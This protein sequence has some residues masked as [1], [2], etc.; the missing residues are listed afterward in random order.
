MGF[1]MM[2][3]PARNWLLPLTAALALAL[4]LS[5]DAF[6][7]P[8]NEPG[9]PQN[10]GQAMPANAPARSPDEAAR[11]AARQYDAAKVLS[12]KTVQQGNRKVHVVKLLTRDGVVKTVRVPADG[13]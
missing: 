3:I 11:Q 5:T 6:A 9:R 4:S 2:K 13:R 10:S 1:R 12:V 7:K 8:R